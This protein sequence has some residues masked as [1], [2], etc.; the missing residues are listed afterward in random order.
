MKNEILKKSLKKIV[1][2]LL[3]LTL[4]FGTGYSSYA[5]NT[6]IHLKLGNFSQLSNLSTYVYIT[7][8][9]GTQQPGVNEHVMT[10]SETA[11]QSPG[12]PT[13]SLVQATKV[14]MTINGGNNQFS[15]TDFS[16][17]V[18]A[19][20]LY[21]IIGNS[22]YYIGHQ[23]KN[24]GREGGNIDDEATAGG[25]MNYQITAL[26]KFEVKYDVNTGTGEVPVAPTLY[27]A[28]TTVNVL[29]NTS[30][31][32][33]ANHVFTGWNTASNGS[34]TS[35]VA[36]NSFVM[37][38][39]DVVLYAQWAP[40][41]NVFYNGNG[42]GTAPIDLTEYK[43]GDKATVATKGTLART[44]YTFAG[45]TTDQDG[46]ESII[47]PSSQITIANADVTL[48]AKWVENKY[49]VEYNGN[50]ATGG[51]AP[52]GTLNYFTGQTVLVLGNVGMFEKLDSTFIGWSTSQNGSTGILGSSIT[53]GTSNVV[54]Y[55]QWMTNQVQQP[56]L[57]KYDSNGKNVV[58]PDNKELMTGSLPWPVGSPSQNEVDNFKFMGWNTSS[59]GLG[60]SYAPG[61]NIIMGTSNI[62]L[63]AQWEEFFK[64]IYLGNGNTSGMPPTDDSKYFQGDEVTV[65]ANVGELK[66][67]HHTFGDW[68]TDENG[69]GITYKTTFVIG[70]KDKTLYAK[71]ILDPSYNVIY[72]ANGATGGSVP[73]DSLEYFT[74]DKPVVIGNTGSLTLPGY[75]FSGWKTDANGSGTAYSA[76][77]LLT[78]AF[79]D[80]ILYAQWTLAPPQTTE[81][82]AAPTTD[83]PQNETTQPPTIDTTEATEELTEELIPEGDAMIINFDEP[84]D[85]ST[86]E[87]MVELETEETPLADALPQ[88]G[89]LPVE[90]F[91]GIGGLITAAGVFLKKK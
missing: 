86:F 2:L 79:S 50:G 41:Y 43:P 1:S 74:G 85:S 62:T 53:M 28:G 38:F 3:V 14:K 75:N 37:G 65:K 9:H 70:N 4:I 20:I 90:L 51:S 17:G 21:F 77:S 35:Y 87:E 31:I 56:H 59:D 57:L 91:Y 73:V 72:N 80:I 26:P 83:E 52:V 55:A 13:A 10:S 34:G 45:W 42:G 16:L 54:M 71:W 39:A 68:N 69:S 7:G 32:T 61:S 22:K 24:V 12:D 36:G 88:T 29:G 27:M 64:V 8:Y 30:S 6:R 84:L 40:R 63:Y 25:T 81:T 33:L 49:T 48:Y 11:P 66:K 5:Q 18:N 23:I 76:S 67:T 78:M 44:N 47:M 89:Q 82:T 46:L 60:T 15:A 58:V 19:K